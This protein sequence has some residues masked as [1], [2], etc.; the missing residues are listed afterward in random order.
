MCIRDSTLA[1]GIF[2]NPFRHC[3]IVYFIVY[4]VH[5]EILFQLFEIDILITKALIYGVDLTKTHSNIKQLFLIPIQLLLTGSFIAYYSMKLTNQEVPLK[6]NMLFN[7]VCTFKKI[8]FANR[9]VP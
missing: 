5:Y 9:P 6:L 2:T 3:R 7:K 8:H 1:P 4:V